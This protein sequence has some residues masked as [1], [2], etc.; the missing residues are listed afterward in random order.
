LHIKELIL[1]AAFDTLIANYPY[2]LSFI[3]GF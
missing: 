1:Y 2:M 3:E